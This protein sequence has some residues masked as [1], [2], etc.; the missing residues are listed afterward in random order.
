[1]SQVHAESG[2]AAQHSRD[3]AAQILAAE[4]RA[5]N[6]TARNQLMQTQMASLQQEIEGLKEALT[7]EKEHYRTDVAGAAEATMSMRALHAQ[8]SNLRSSVKIVEHQLSEKTDEAEQ[9]RTML[10]MHDDSA[11]TAASAILSAQL[12][13]AS[14]DQALEDSRK[15][16]SCLQRRLDMQQCTLQDAQADSAAANDTADAARR[17]VAH[18]AAEVHRATLRADAAVAH[19]SGIDAA[20][21]S[22]DADLA[23][24]RAMLLQQHTVSGA[25]TVEASTHTKGLE[26]QV[27]G[28]T[29]R[30]QVLEKQLQDRE[31]MLETAEKSTGDMKDKVEAASVKAAQQDSELSHMHTQLRAARKA[32]EQ[33]LAVAAERNA[34]L[35]MLRNELSELLVNQDAMAQAGAETVRSEKVLRAG[36]RGL[37]S[38]LR[39]VHAALARKD[40]DAVATDEALANC[41]DEYRA[42]RS[43]AASAHERCE[44]LRKQVRSLQSNVQRHAAV[45]QAAQ[46][47]VQ[48]A[49]QVALDEAKRAD[50]VEGHVANLEKV[51]QR[52]NVQQAA[53]KAAQDRHN[54]AATKAAEAVA[55]T[56]KI[57]IAERENSVKARQSAVDAG[58]LVEAMQ[59]EVQQLRSA[60]DAQLHASDAATAATQDL[61]Q[62]LLDQQAE[63]R[64]LA[65]EASAAASHAASS[66]R[67]VSM[68]QSQL[69][70]I[71]VQMHEQTEAL[72]LAEQQ[73]QQTAT[74]RVAEHVGAVRA[75]QSLERA[76][77]NVESLH[78][79]LGEKEEGVEVCMFFSS[80]NLRLLS[81][82][83]AL[84]SQALSC[85][86]KIFHF[87]SHAMQSC[88]LQL[89]HQGSKCLRILV[90]GGLIYMDQE[91]LAGSAAATIGHRRPAAEGEP[92]AWCHTSRASDSDNC[93][94]QKSCCSAELRSRE[95]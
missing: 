74:D 94:G 95:R 55:D 51:V 5:K 72:I 88:Q 61:Q 12:A 85:I 62:A 36:L 14:R 46:D 57:A 68:L 63:V 1:M 82:V 47:G 65:A 22:A 34:E 93:T 49:H 83:I 53:L 42:A 3:A 31:K 48:E 92:G 18:L 76:G 4:Q 45:A 41:R 30:L 54:T 11:Q 7:D 78:R 10:A 20:L 66:S 17:Q 79:E 84:K 43:E 52:F 15:R 24:V 25:A 38:E 75:A 69:I 9:M 50:D 44:V 26:A 2:G 64:V 70:A 67:E 73:L 89:L 19:A 71:K 87:H 13:E 90:S 23:E 39:S 40:A 35:E 60:H 8:I 21:A 32:H 91:V 59:Q 27:R 80:C 86:S 6:L 16:A 77:A 56:R 37:D 33:A 58:A 28:M 81:S 29:V